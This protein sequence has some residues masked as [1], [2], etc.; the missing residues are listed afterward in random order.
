[1]NTA[2]IWDRRIFLSSLGAM[3]AAAWPGN[4]LAR[5]R[6]ATA[7]AG[8]SGNI[9][10]ELGVKTIINAWGTITLIGGS[11]IP[12]EAVAAMSAAAEHYVSIPDLLEATGDRIAKMLKDLPADHSATVTSGAAGAIM[13]GVAGTLTGE[14]K[15]LIRQLPDLTGMK[16]EVL[17]LKSQ[18]RHY[19]YNPQI[20]ASGVKIVEVESADD[21]SRAVS[22]KTALMFFANY[23]DDNSEIKVA[24]W[25]KLGK[26]HNVPTFNDCAADTPPVSHLTDYNNMGYDLVAFSGGKGL[27]GPQCSGLLLGRKDLVR[28]ARFNGAPFAPTIGRGMKVGKEEIVGMWKA[29]EVYLSSDHE[30]LTQEW[31]DRLHYISKELRSFSGVYTAD[32][33]PPIANHVPTMRVEWDTQ[34]VGLTSTQARA[35]LESDD[36]AVMVGGG[37]G[38]NSI[39]MASFMLKPGEER[40]VAARLKAMFKAHKA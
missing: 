11:L 33:V 15:E 26:Q 9:Y 29:L 25:A 1:M 4:A 18:H 30:K 17:M 23:M 28:A 37:P 13:S 31:W 6:K 36:P 12:P 14:N 7:A 34:K 5:G 8:A 39:T 32:L 19:G 38:E 24:D 3:A 10:K 22:E 40:I 35:F 21:V 20:L 16:S 2:G 27:R